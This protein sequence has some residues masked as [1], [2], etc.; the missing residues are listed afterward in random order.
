MV[1]AIAIL[2]AIHA[3]LQYAVNA[4]VGHLDEYNPKLLP[5]IP[6]LPEALARA[7][8]C[9]CLVTGNLQDIGWLKM[10]KAGLKHCFVTGV[11]VITHWLWRCS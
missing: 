11:D 6:A 8:V 5:G 2:T 10:E 3:E 1:E 4:I 7:G 9:V